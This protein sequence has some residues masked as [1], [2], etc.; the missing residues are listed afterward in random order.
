MDVIFNV[1]RNKPTRPV[2]SNTPKPAEVKGKKPTFVERKVISVSNTGNYE[3][4]AAE[5]LAI[6]GLDSSYDDR[7][8]REYKRN[9]MY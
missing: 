7:L 5:D 8:E 9:G 6:E 1:K 4:L 3:H 2:K